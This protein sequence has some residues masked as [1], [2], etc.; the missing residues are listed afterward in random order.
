MLEEYSIINIKQYLWWQNNFMYNYLRFGYFLCDVCMFN[1]LISL[2]KIYMYACVFVNVCCMFYV[3]CCMLHVVCV[4]E[5]EIPYNFLWFPLVFFFVFF[6]LF[7]SH[8]YKFHLY[9]CIM[10]VLMYV[11]NFVYVSYV[12]SLALNYTY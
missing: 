10:H 6:I 5:N 12:V 2:E 7:I 9:M 1:M 3:S 4:Y 11:Y 8:L